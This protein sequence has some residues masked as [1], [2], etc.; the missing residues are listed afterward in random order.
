MTP[1]LGIMASQISGHLIPAT[2]YESIAT[3]TVG[4]GGAT[5]EVEFT[6]IPATYKHLQIRYFAGANGAYGDDTWTR[7]IVNGQTTASGNYTRHMLSGDGSTVSS[8]SSTTGSNTNLFFLLPG[9]TGG[10]WASG[11]TNIL[12]YTDTNKYRTLQ[13]FTGWYGNSGGRNDLTSHLYLS[14]TAVSTIKIQMFSG[15]FYRQYSRFALYGI[16]GA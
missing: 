16:K 15:E 13:T 8:S 3:V 4:S 12:D 14:T 6:S 2:D 9:A 1:I 10:G 11:V 5:T 7:L